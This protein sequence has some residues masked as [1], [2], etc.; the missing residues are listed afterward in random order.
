MNLKLWYIF[1]WQLT[2]AYN[3]FG[4]LTFEFSIK[5]VCKW[6]IVG[7]LIYDVNN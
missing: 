1:S 2:M 6:E 4:K 7:L 3:F 5:F